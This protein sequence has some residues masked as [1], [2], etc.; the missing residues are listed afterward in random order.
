M[1]MR[2][3]GPSRDDEELW[4]QP[5]TSEAGKRE[6]GVWEVMVVDDEEQVHQVTRLVLSDVVFESKGL[7]LLHAYSGNEAIALLEAHPNTALIL[8]D[9]VMETDD[10][11][12]GVVRRIRQESKN[13]FVRIVLRTGQPGQAPE[14]DVIE[15]YDIHDYKEKSD[16]TAQKLYTCVIAS[17]RAYRD[18]RI[19]EANRKG[20]ERIIESASSILNLQSMD[21]FASSV[22]D[23][24]GTLLRLSG[25]SLSR[26]K[27]SRP[28]PTGFTAIGRHGEFCILAATG[29]YASAVGKNLQEI[30]PPERMAD[31]R[32]VIRSCRSLFAK[33]YCLGYSRTERG[34]EF[35]LYLENEQPLSEFD[36]ALIELFCKNIAIGYDNVDLREEI[37]HELHLAKM[38]FGESLT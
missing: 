18:L 27:E 30:I 32:H 17:L 25:A 35:L 37:C 10:A 31:L 22:L 2:S 1:T 33:E 28:L 14:R 11:G 24:I 5:E 8:L 23:Q 21:R 4:Y 19:I 34:S 36:I 29:K 13:P 26:W 12:L 7:R 3:D 16:L 9:V 15:S 20:L 6:S 38:R